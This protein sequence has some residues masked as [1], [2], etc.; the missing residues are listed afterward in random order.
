[1]AAVQCA[2]SNP[3]IQVALTAVANGSVACSE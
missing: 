1:M 3:V 2:L